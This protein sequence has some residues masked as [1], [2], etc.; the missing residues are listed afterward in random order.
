MGAP[1]KN[2]RHGRCFDGEAHAECPHETALLPVVRRSAGLESVGPA[3]TGPDPSPNPGARAH[4]THRATGLRRA[5]AR[6]PPRALARWS[7]RA[8]R[9]SDVVARAGESAGRPGQPPAGSRLDRRHRDGRGQQR[10]AAALSGTRPAQGQTF[11][12]GY[13]RSDLFNDAV[14]ARGHCAR[15][16]ARRPARRWRVQVN[17]FR[18]SNDTFVN[19]Y[20]KYERSPQMDYYG[21]G[22]DRA[23]KTAPAIS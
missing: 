10:V 3:S 23:R 18:R 14:T 1:R 12:I 9:R 7:S 13:R 11:G 4:A 20:I 16:V 21:L 22:A 8:A 6:S 2:I 15:H 5:G 17:Q 19:L